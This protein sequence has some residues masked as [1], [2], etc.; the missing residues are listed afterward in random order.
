MNILF[1]VCVRV[2]VH[3]HGSE[4]CMVE[5]ISKQP[6]Q[7]HQFE[8]TGPIQA[9]ETLLVQSTL[10]ANK[11]RQTVEFGTWYQTAFWVVLMWGEWVIRGAYNKLAF[12]NTEEM[13]M[14]G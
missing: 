2:C 1:S 9:R 13:K 5:P 6:Q 4:P 3:S 10:T 7:I 12:R 8:Q 11:Q 14:I